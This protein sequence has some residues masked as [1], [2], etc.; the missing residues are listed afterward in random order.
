MA[1][2]TQSDADEGGISPKLLAKMAR[3]SA[4]YAE[5]LAARADLAA[6]HEDESEAAEAIR[7]ER[8]RAAELALATTPAPHSSAIWQKWEFLDFLMTDEIDAGSPI[9]PLAI[10]ALASL[11]ADIAA[12]GLPHWPQE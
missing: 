10:V 8:E 3:F 1:N 2:D 11:K 6:K 4:A 12:L 7:Y 5:W 9:Y